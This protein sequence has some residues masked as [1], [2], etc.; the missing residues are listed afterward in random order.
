[1]RKREAKKKRKLAQNETVYSEL[2]YDLEIDEV[3]NSDYKIVE[4]QNELEVLKKV[5]INKKDLQIARNRITAQLSR[6][7]K[8]IEGDYTKQEFISMKRKI[9]SL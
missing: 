6:D 4:M 3:V 5:E 9:Q 7:R 2:D 8:K 1:M